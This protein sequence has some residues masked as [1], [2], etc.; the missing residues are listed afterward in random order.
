V[1]LLLV[2]TTRG[3]GCESPALASRG[4]VFTR[5]NATRRRRRV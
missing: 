3:V 1:S 5:A 2:V 4:K